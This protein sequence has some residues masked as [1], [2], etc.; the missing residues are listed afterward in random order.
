[1]IHISEIFLLIIILLF[2]YYS[3]LGLCYVIYELMRKQKISRDLIIHKRKR[4][5]NFI[6]NILRLEMKFEWD[7]RHGICRLGNRIIFSLSNYEN[8]G[9]YSLLFH[10]IKC[11]IVKRILLL[12]Q[13]L[14]KDLS[15]YTILK[16]V[17][18]LRIDL[19]IPSQSFI[20]DIERE[21]ILTE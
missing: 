10:K 13:L 20:C 11:F 18:I 2:S 19:S 6:E 15:Y 12:R 8:Q 21:I 7:L 9:I 16:I 3:F 17:K 5:D 4:I 1:M 14:M